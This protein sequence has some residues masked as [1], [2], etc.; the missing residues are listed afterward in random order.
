MNLTPTKE[1]RA[2]IVAI[3]SSEAF[4]DPDDMAREI[5]KASYALLSERNA[6]GV[7]IGLPTDDL[8][9]AHGPWYNIGDAKRVV[10]EAQA[11]GLRAFVARLYGP[12]HA[13]PDVEESTYKICQCGHPK[14]LHGEGKLSTVGCGVFDRKTKEQCSCRHFQA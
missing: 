12:A 11:R 1:E 5:L 3:L 14:P 9:L 10:K 13:L 6:Y 2:A 4:E 8:V 7:G